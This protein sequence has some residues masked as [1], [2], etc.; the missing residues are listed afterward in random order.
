MVW[1]KNY[2]RLQHS[3]NQREPSQGQRFWI[4]TEN[5]K[6]FPEEAAGNGL[7]GSGQGGFQ[8]LCPTLRIGDSTF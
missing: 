7:W 1:L 4:Q 3:Y 8:L 5:G 6:M 2:S